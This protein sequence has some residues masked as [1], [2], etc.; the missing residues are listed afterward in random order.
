M[1]FKDLKERNVGSQDY[2]MMDIE[3]YPKTPWAQF[4]QVLDRGFSLELFKGLG[5]TF[6][7]MKGVFLITNHTIQNTQ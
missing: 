5:I 1:S 2:I 4:K 3:E 7:I 6:K